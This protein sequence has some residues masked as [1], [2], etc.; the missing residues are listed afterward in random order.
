VDQA[1]LRLDGPSNWLVAPAPAAAA[2][3]ATAG[4]ATALAAGSS[5]FTEYPDS[6]IAEEM[7][8]RQANV[9][10]FILAQR[11][12]APTLLLQRLLHVRHGRIHSQLEQ[13]QTTLGPSHFRTP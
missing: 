1:G 2:A 9:S 4:A 6:F 11:N 12:L 3:A 5:Q 7:E 8:R 10:D 13:A